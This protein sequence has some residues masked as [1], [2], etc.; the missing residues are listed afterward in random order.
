MPPGENDFFVYP[1]TLFAFSIP[2]A[3][4][5]IYLYALP[6][7]IIAVLYGFRWKAGMWSNC[8]SL[9]CVLFAILV[10]VGWWED[11]AY[12]LATQVP[13]MLFVADG[14]AIWA[15]FVITLALLD[16]ATRG[17]SSIKVKYADTVEKVGNGLVLFVLFLALY[18]FYLFAEDVG[19]VGEHHNVT[20]SDS[21]LSPIP[22]FRMLSA[23]NL[24]GFTEVSQFDDRGDF[25]E[26][27]LKRRQSLMELTQ[28]QEGMIRIGYGGDSDDVEKLRRRN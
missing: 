20:V 18:G 3:L 26:L 15:L 12:L 5:A 13:A 6:I 14:I 17:M 4:Y 27:H 7:V 10:A 1:M 19:P 8:V 28:G 11:L 2:A 21:M 23:G 25:R 24:S 16:L 22:M 9:G